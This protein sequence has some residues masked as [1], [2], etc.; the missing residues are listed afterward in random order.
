MRDI[1]EIIASMLLVLAL[2]IWFAAVVAVPIG[3]F[4]AVVQTVAGFFNDLFLVK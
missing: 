3:V 1:F 4:I 2:F